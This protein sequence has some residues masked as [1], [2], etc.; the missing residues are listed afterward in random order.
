MNRVWK[1]LQSLDRFSPVCVCVCVCVFSHRLRFCLD[2]VRI[3]TIESRMQ[4]LQFKK[5]QT[6]APSPLC[7]PAPSPCS[8]P[9]NGPMSGLLTTVP[10]AAAAAASA[11]VILQ[12]HSLAHSQMMSMMP[13]SVGLSPLSSTGS[14]CSS[15]SSSSSSL[16]SPSQSA[17][18]KCTPP[19]NACAYSSHED[20]KPLGLKLNL[21]VDKAP[22]MSNFSIDAIMS[23]DAE[24]VRIKSGKSDFIF[25]FV[26]SRWMR[27]L[28]L[29]FEKSSRAT[30]KFSVIIFQY[31]VS[32]WTLLAS[33]RLS[34]HRK[35]TNVF[36]AYKTRKSID[37][38]FQLFSVLSLQ[39]AL[40]CAYT[41]HNT[42]FG[43]KNWLIKKSFPHSLY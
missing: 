17:I 29:T 43:Q 28:K 20:I 14:V 5:M 10:A 24:S 7:S 27:F 2:F 30:N 34:I 4:L 33:V 6:T 32:L 39:R 11:A 19:S 1:H 26:S 31:R 8:S 15:S 13:A 3:V 21:L 22:K 23:R 12:N 41:L 36:M 18:D 38:L 25:R 35:K 37:F 9:I 40:V 16:G 42:A